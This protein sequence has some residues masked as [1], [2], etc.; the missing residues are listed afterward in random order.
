MVAVL[1]S[2]PQC[3]ACRAWKTLLPQALGDIAQAFFEVD[4]SAATGVAR[5][6]DIFHLPTIY[7]F[8][9]GVFHAELQCPTRREAIRETALALLAAE[10]QDEP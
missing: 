4:V 6:Y 9:D 5:Y 3:S 10:A 7:L 2:A 8:R 1:F